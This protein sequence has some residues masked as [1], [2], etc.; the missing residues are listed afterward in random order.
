MASKSAAARFNS[1]RFAASANLDHAQFSRTFA[2][3]F[4]N[5]SYLANREKSR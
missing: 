2:L 3:Y 5:S 1:V 4:R